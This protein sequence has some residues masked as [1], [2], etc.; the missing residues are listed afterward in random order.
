MVKSQ[1]FYR[2]QR[3]KLRRL[4]S[5]AIIINYKIESALISRFYWKYAKNAIVKNA[6]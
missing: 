1:K 5:Q 3:Y 4:S 6:K 2:L